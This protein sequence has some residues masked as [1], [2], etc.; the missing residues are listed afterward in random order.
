MTPPT[1]EVSSL[2][3]LAWLVEF[4]ELVG[5]D[6]CA[7]KA[8]SIFQEPHENYADCSTPITSQRDLDSIRKRPGIIEHGAH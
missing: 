2:K 6:V 8:H 3:P 7:P 4:D 1:P 5:L